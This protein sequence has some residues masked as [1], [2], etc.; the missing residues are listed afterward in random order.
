M[1]NLKL[2]LTV[3]LCISSIISCFCWAKSALAK[4]PA[5]VPGTILVWTDE[6]GFQTDLAATAKAQT[7]WNQIAA[8]FASVAAITQGIL[9]F[10]TW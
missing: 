2:L 5:K 3:L 9:A 10:A 8:A 4:V 1:N 7:K 6:S